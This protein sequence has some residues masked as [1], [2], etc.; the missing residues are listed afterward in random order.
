MAMLDH[1]DATPF[2]PQPIRRTMDKKAIR[3]ELE[4]QACQSLRQGGVIPVVTVL[5]VVVPPHAVM[6]FTAKC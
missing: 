1:M 3:F 2:R 6:I 4:R 5:Y